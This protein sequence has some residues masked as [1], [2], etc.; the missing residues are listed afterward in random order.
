AGLRIDEVI[1][2]WYK[3]SPWK[4]TEECSKQ[5]IEN[6]IVDRVIELVIAEGEALPGVPDIFDFFKEQHIPMA[7]ASSSK[8]K[9]IDAVLKKLD[10][11]GYFELVYSAEDEPYG[12]PH[13]GIFI[14]TAAKLTVEPT[15]CIVFEDSF[16]GILAGL[17]ARM[18]VIAIP[19]GVN[20]THPKFDIA[21]K[22]LKSLLEFD[23]LCLNELI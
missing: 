4:E 16:N 5:A 22:K 13:P 9:I 14:T 3:K 8:Y 19:E 17:S 23:L 20:Y 21:T 7:V 1:A 6:Q 2:H 18:H 15:D 10:I 12:K 11:Q